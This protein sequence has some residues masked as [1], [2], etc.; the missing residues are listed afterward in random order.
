MTTFQILTHTFV[1]HSKY[2]YIYK[3]TNAKNKLLEDV[4]DAVS[5]MPK[6]E[7]ANMSESLINITS[8]KRKASSDI[9]TVGREIDVALITKGD[10]F[11][12]IK[13]KHFFDDELNYYFF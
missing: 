3:I 10:G 1:F 8:L 6:E 4:K 9:E 12:W 13:R 7:V 5:V 2:F 11:I